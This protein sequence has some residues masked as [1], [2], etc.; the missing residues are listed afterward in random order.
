MNVWFTP[1]ALTVTL[2]AAIAVGLASAAT[3]DV[4]DA[5]PIAKSDRLPIIADAS[6]YITVRNPRRRYVGAPALSRSTDLHILALCYKRFLPSL[7]LR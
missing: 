2:T 1:V 3:L 7:W 5:T 4:V 6:T